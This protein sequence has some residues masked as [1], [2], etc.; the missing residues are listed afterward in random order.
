VNRPFRTH[1]ARSRL[2]PGETLRNTRVPFIAP[3]VVSAS[4]F[5]T[6]IP[7][8]ISLGCFRSLHVLYVIELCTDLLTKAS[9]FE[10]LE[11]T[12]YSQD[13]GIG[14]ALL[15]RPSKGRHDGPLSDS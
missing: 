8:H 6:N 13:M 1:R 15:R 5:A 3:V 2:K 12:N 11:P 9:Q 7:I 4:T 14:T 10:P